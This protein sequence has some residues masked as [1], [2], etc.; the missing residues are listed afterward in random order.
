MITIKNLYRF[1]TRASTLK[2]TGMCMTIMLTNIVP[3]HFLISDFVINEISDIRSINF[4]SSFERAGI[5]LQ[6]PSY[7]LQVISCCFL[8]SVSSILIHHWVNHLLNTVSRWFGFAVVISMALR[9]YSFQRTEGSPSTDI[10]QET[11]TET[12]YISNRI[13]MLSFLPHSSLN[14][15]AF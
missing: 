9:D 3:C 8:A 1:P 6:F 13:S 2:Q 15:P 14:I 4:C 12:K 5:S 10:K 11:E 7:I